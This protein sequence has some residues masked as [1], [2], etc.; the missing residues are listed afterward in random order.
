MIFFVTLLY[1]SIPWT[2]RN[3]SVATE[4][5]PEVSLGIF[6]L[7]MPLAAALMI[8]FNIEVL[9]GYFKPDAAKSTEV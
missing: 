3:F 8:L 6:Y 1:I 4:S 2:V 7:C 5:I 9:L